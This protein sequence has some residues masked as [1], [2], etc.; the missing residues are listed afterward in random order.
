MLKSAVVNFLGSNCVF[1]TVAALEKTGFS[2]EIITQNHTK[3]E[4]YDLIVLPGGFSYGDYIN[5]GRIAKFSPVINSIKEKIKNKNVFVLG[6]CNGFQ[7]L[8]EAGILPGAL[9][10]NVNQKFIC[11]DVELFFNDRRFSLPIAHAGGRYYIDDL[12]KLKNFDLIK[13]KKNPNGSIE[14]IAGI[15]DKKNRILGLMPHP[16]RNLTTPF[17]KTGG[18]IIFD[19]I[20]EKLNEIV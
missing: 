12:K 10:L 18:K 7:I 20:R 13:Y 16:E 2:P 8:C 19:F 3:L 6:I 15:Y 17:K 1:E 4:N 11:D 5:C 9:V 14:N